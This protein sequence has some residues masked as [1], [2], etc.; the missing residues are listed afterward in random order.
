[1]NKDFEKKS[2]EEL[3][4]LQ[5]EIEELI[6]Q[7]QK[8]KKAELKKQFQELAEKAG[9]S[10][11]EILSLKKEP[12]KIKI[13]YKKDSNTWSGRGRRPVWVAELVEK[14]GNIEDFLVKEA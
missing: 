5:K 10:L 4:I 14:G 1:M 2:I 9:L 7:K 13:K 3:V 11:D 12:K 8:E 6:L